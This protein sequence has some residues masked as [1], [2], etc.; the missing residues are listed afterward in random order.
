VRFRSVEKMV[1]EIVQV[2]KTYGTIQFMFKDDSFTL[3][4]KRVKAF[5]HNLLD[6][7]VSLL[8]EC[9]TRLDLM[10]DA[11]IKLMKKAGCNRIGVGVESGDEEILKILNKKLTKDQI[12]QGTNI[13][14]KNNIF[15]TGY[16]MMGLPMERE[17]QVYHTLEF[18]RELR[19]PYA[20]LGIY[21]PYPCT[22]LFELAAELGLVEENV[23]NEYFF[24]TNPVDYFLKDPHRRNAYIP[25]ARLNGLIVLLEKEFDHSNKKL[26]NLSKRAWAR[27]KLYLHDPKSLVVDLRRAVKWLI[28]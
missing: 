27:Q 12:R 28:N 20:A 8:W 9:A 10:D 11:L 19:P 25:E 3:N 5:C 23:P 22:R 14:N 1:E 2:Q 6:N 16:F 15:W 21:K 13:L 17:E 24:T 26:T 4:R 18:M 7:N